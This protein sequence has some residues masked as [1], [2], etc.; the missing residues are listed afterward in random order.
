MKKDT[1]YVSRE[2]QRILK[3]EKKDNEFLNR[4]YD[5]LKKGKQNVNDESLPKSEDEK[6][7]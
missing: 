7:E 2:Y 4:K 6:K 3:K 1:K 5:Q